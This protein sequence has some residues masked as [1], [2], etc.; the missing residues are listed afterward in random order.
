MLTFLNVMK[1]MCR[2]Q[3]GKWKGRANINAKVAITCPLIKSLLKSVDLS[4]ARVV[5]KLTQLSNLYFGWFSSNKYAEN[6]FV[7]AGVFKNPNICKK[8]LNKHLRR[9]H[10]CS[11]AG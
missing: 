4:V 1:K 3:F 11:R 5:H 6:N 10:L 8:R 9:P 7:S 2:H